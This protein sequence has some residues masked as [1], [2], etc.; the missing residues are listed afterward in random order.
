[1]IVVAHFMGFYG[2]ERRR[3]GDQ[4][5]VPDGTKS[6]WFSPVGEK[7]A[8]GKKAPALPGPA[9]APKAGG[10]KAPALPS[11]EPAKA[12]DGRASDKNL[13]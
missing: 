1:M 3:P 8:G 12:D 5:E 7:L 6:K 11:D 13:I 4:F 10:K 9:V 2:G